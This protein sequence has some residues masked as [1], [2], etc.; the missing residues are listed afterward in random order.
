[1]KPI[2]I[3]TSAF[4]ALISRT[5]RFHEKAKFVYKNLIDEEKTLYTS[6]YVLVE[7]IALINHRLGFETLKKFMENFENII[8]TIYIDRCRPIFI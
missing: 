8:K 7:T 2:F 6:S 3:D 1:M 5:D 4:Y